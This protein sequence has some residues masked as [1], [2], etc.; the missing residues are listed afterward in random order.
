VDRRAFIG[1]LAS[2]LLA[3][4]LAVGGQPAGKVYRVAVLG[5]TPTPPSLAAAFKQGLGQFGYTEGGNIV[6][7]YRDAGGQPERLSQLA[8][9][10]NA[11][12]IFARG[13]RRAV[14]C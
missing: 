3:A 2:G 13:G 7:E 6:I 8:A 1:S 11:D 10:L 5:L 9:Q 14:S 12:V 4:P